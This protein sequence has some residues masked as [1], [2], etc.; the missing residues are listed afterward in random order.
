MNGNAI[1]AV[2]VLTSGL[3]SLA[4][5]HDTKTTTGRAKN[6]AYF[7]TQ[8]GG[9]HLSESGLTTVATVTVELDSAAEVLVQF[10]SE[11]G[12]ADALGCPCSIR[13]ALTLDDGDPQ[14]VKRI[15]VGTPAVQAVGKYD[16][17]REN[18]D[19]SYVFSLPAGKH[20]ISLG[21]QLAYGASKSLEVYYP[22]LQA[23]AFPKP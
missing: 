4:Q 14:V 15:N 8:S 6:L 19:G 20:T 10:T 16:Q 5:A 9:T 21:Y 1:F 12:A 3:C 2:L 23:I 18:I 7:N 13:A 22:N 11:V 17:D